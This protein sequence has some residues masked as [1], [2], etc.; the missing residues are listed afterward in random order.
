[1][2]QGN[3]PLVLKSRTADVLVVIQVQG[4]NEYYATNYVLGEIE[5]AFSCHH[6]CSLV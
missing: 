6:L 2:V 3:P 1:M 4:L 5:I